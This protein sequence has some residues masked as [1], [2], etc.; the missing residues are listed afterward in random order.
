MSNSITL[1]ADRAAAAA[2]APP[3]RIRSEQ[4]PDVGPDHRQRAVPAAASYLTGQA[5]WVWVWAYHQWL[6]GT[7]ER[8]SAL[9]VGAVYRLPGGGIAHD[10]LMPQSLATRGMDTARSGGHRAL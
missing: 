4:L 5:V 6:P 10:E 8:S 2:Q 1:G 3:P 9:S 7:V